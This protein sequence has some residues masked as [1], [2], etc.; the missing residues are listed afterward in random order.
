VEL[1][2]RRRGEEP[3]QDTSG[4]ARAHERCVDEAILQRLLSRSDDF[5]LAAEDLTDSVNVISESAHEN[6]RA[7]AVVTSASDRVNAEASSVAGAARE[8][9]SA[10]SEVAES[11]SEATRVTAEAQDVAQD[12]LGSVQRLAASTEQI[13]GVVKA[14]TGISDQTRLLA[15]NATIEAA[16]AGSAGKGF[17]VV[18]DEVKHLASETGE[19]TTTITDQLGQLAGDSDTVRLAVERI[20]E[21]LTRVDALQQT[22][23]AAVEQQ[24]A[25][26]AEITRSA[27]EASNA[28]AD[29]DQ[30]V[31]GSAE[32]AKQ[33]DSS[34]T[35]ATTWLERLGTAA[36]SQR[37]EVNAIGVSDVH[38]V[39]AAIGAHALWKARL[40]KA[41]RTG[42]L[43]RGTTIEAVARDDGC[44]FGQWL[45][46]GEA[47]RL[48]PDRAKTI[49]TQH[50]RFHTEAAE[51]LRAATAGHGDRARQL[52]S[53]RDRYGG[54]AGDLTDAL[55]D[56][57]RVVEAGHLSDWL[58]RRGAHRYPVS[59]PVT[60]RTPDRTL[61]GETIDLSET[62]AR[63]RL[64]AGSAPG[65]GSGIEI[66]LAVGNHR[67]STRAEVVHTQTGTDADEVGLRFLGLDAAD[68][69]ALRAYVDGLAPLPPG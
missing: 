62:G 53:D 8:M 35:R 63:C 20:A 33:A 36:L 23:A 15:L 61:P 25:A 50:A 10:M 2:R 4:A 21:V 55:L 47:A 48:D 12:V 60:L 51:V 65:V 17:A 3:E 37:D 27:S 46:G 11:A 66:D 68:T 38:P 24:T 18:A 57:V 9:S 28:A 54:V 22:I 19:A 16:R 1:R 39:R 69:V 58:E 29:L 26:I 7:M 6:T 13:D 52:M 44:P 32:A 56:W 45:H 31:T 34:V 41:I 64:A 67:M 49:T 42:R 14:V 43:E 5:T 59:G 40:R 30:A